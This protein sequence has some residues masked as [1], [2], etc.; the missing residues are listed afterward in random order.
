MNY[1]QFR[2]VKLTVVIVVAAVISQA[3]IYANYWLAAITVTIALIFLLVLKRKIKEVVADERDY[4]IAGDAARYAVT[5]FVFLAVVA[6]F[7]LMSLKDVDI[8]Y[9]VVGIVLAYSACF[10]MLFYSLTYVYLNKAVPIVRRLSFIVVAIVIILIF[11]LASL[12]LFTSEDT[13]VCEGGQ[14]IK[15]GQ[16]DINIPVEPCNK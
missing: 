6:S 14:W 1:K 12:R 16:P 8:V 2:A 10:L 15:Y 7:I 13:W 5:V 4:K 3:V 11:I 9:T